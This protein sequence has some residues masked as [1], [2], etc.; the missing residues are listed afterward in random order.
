MIRIYKEQDLDRMTEIW[1]EA[2]LLAHPFIKADYWKEQADAMRNIYLISSQNFVYIDENGEITGFVAM[3]DDYLAAIFV[4][5]DKQGQGI[6]KKL[7][8][9][10]KHNHNTIT[11]TV[12]SRNEQAIQFYKREGFEETEE[13]TDTNTGEKEWLMTYR[14]L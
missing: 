7:L 11:L 12:Y 1:L 10:V 2:S 3:V 5:P 4:T 9:E 8:D 6:G 14:R 13:R